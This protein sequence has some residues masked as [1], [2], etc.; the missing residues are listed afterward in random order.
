MMVK[1]MTNEL[2]IMMDEQLKPGAQERREADVRCPRKRGPSG[3]GG[4][5]GGAFRGNQ[6]LG[7][8]V[9]F[10]WWLGGGEGSTLL[11][12]ALTKQNLE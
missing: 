7:G 10:L 1:L 3:G 12:D 2:G 4:E 6:Q 11:K 8:S 5:G 9:L